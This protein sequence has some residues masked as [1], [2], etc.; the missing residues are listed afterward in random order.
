MN[1]LNLLKMCYLITAW[2][3]NRITDLSTGAQTMLL[4][5]ASIKWGICKAPTGY[6]KSGIIFWNIAERI[7]HAI[8][9]NEKLVITLS[10]PLL[11]L[12]DQFYQDLIEFLANIDLGLNSTNC[13]FVDNSSVQA[14]QRGIVNGLNID[15][16]G[17]VDLSAAIKNKA[18]PQIV[19][20]ISTHKSYNNFLSTNNNFVLSQL[21]DLGY[22]IATYFDECHTIVDANANGKNSNSMIESD[23]DPVYVDQLKLVAD[24]IYFFSAT[25]ALW[26]ATWFVT[27]YAN[28]PKGYNGFVHEVAIIDALNEKQIL[29][30]EVTMCEVEDNKDVTTIADTLEKIMA[31]DFRYG[32]R[33]ILVTCM[34]TQ[35][36]IA[37][38]DELLN[39][40]GIPV[41]YT[42][43]AFGKHIHQNLH[44]DTTCQTI[45]DFSK[46]IE[47]F[48]GNM[49]I[50]H[51]RQMIAG[52][53]VPAIT[54]VVNRVFDNTAQNVVKM[55][56]TNGRALRVRKCDRACFKNGMDWT[57]TKIVGE[58]YNIIEKDKF[59]DDAKFLSR[60]FNL[61]YNTVNVKVFRLVRKTTTPGG[62]YEL[63][64]NNVF[65]GVNNNACTEA[66]FYYFRFLQKFC[67]TNKNDIKLAREN[68]EF[69]IDVLENACDFINASTASELTVIQQDTIAS[70][71]EAT[72]MHQNAKAEI[73]WKVKDL[74]DCGIFS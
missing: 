55:I 21:K 60:F 6:G 38:R 18:I 16:W 36:L 58:V 35:E 1:K 54:T 7:K 64:L 73:M 44:T 50:L 62:K 31:S 59:T 40:R 70:L 53:D 10:T 28:A 57:A 34:N 51:I 45:T 22:C 48:N 19:I 69:Q 11:V 5:M 8:E 15:R 71:E 37:L 52:V 72:F 29:P 20:C 9:N 4:Q 49:I 26:Q 66:T 39:N 43:A 23:S 14:N 17:F 65:S 41:A 61:I 25:P 3:M 24:Y 33:K 2:I 30:P 13:V 12:N 27:N 32:Y 46:G 74:F 47:D 68:P 63:D 42:C 67:E 56:Q